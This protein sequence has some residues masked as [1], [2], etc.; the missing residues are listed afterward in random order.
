[1]VLVVKSEGGGHGERRRL[2]GK[3]LLPARESGEGQGCRRQS[4]SQSEKAFYSL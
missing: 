1:M 3:V 4:R 2:L